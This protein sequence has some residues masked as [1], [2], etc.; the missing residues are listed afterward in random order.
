MNAAWPDGACWARV[1]ARFACV[2]CGQLSPQ[3]HLDLDGAVTCAHCGF[4]QPL[5]PRAWGRPLAFAHEVVDLSAVAPWVLASETL[6][7]HRNPHA[8]VGSSIP[9]REWTETGAV[10]GRERLQV[11][12]APG[13]PL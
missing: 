3:N 2:S 8:T 12:V 11:R 13:H 4:D 6:R 5:D 7:S 9:A 1:E 10:A